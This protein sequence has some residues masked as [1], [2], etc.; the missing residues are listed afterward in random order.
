MSFELRCLGAEV[1]GATFEASMAGMEFLLRAM[2][3]QEVLVMTPIPDPAL[4]HL[5]SFRA[6]GIG[7]VPFAKFRSADG[8]HLVPEECLSISRVLS[9]LLMDERKLR[10]L[11]DEFGKPWDTPESDLWFIQSF[12]DFCRKASNAG[13]FT[14]HRRAEPALQAVKA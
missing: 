12:A 3:A 10:T 13:G 4:A 5:R 2:A 6:K 7:K 1:P 14:V 9:A 8:W 11:F